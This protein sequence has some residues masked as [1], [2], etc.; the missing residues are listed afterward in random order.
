M[1]AVQSLQGGSWAAIMGVVGI[2]ALIANGGAALMFYRFRG[3][4]ANMR[5]VWICH[6]IDPGVAALVK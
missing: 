3:G 2:A 4:N 1:P 5:S 6:A